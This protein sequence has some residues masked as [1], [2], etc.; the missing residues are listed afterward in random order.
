MAVGEIEVGPKSKGAE[1]AAEIRARMDARNQARAQRAGEGSGESLFGTVIDAVNPLQ[2]I[3]GV[4]SVY[5]S[6]TGDGASPIASMAGGFLFGGPMGLMAGAASSFIEIMTGKS[7]AEHAMA[8]LDTIG[9]EG[10]GAGE[11]MLAS[12][13]MDPTSGDALLGSAT[14]PRAEH[15]ASILAQANAE[16]RPGF[17][18]EK[19]TVEYSANIWAG[20]AL[21]DVTDKYDSANRLNTNS[22]KSTENHSA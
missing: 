13:S 6:V 17:G 2:H 20:R 9:E 14:S 8:L 15:E 22:A 11:T 21:A 4:S 12:K 5:Q 16:R 1:I 7:P 18:A 19:S 10:V 3:P